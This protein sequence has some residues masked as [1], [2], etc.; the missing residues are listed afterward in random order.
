MLTH[1]FGRQSGCRDRVKWQSLLAW[2]DESVSCLF[3][4]A[5]TY[6][7]A[8]VAC[9]RQWDTGCSSITSSQ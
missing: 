5:L 4:V 2:F 6:R 7:L 8:K 3:C 9:Q 1:I